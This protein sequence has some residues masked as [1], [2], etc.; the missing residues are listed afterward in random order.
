MG[1]PVKT[2]VDY[3]SHDA[4]ASDRKTLTILTKHF[5]NDGYAA[6][7]RLLEQLAKSE[8][9][10]YDCQNAENFEYLEAKFN[11]SGFS[12]TEILDKLSEIGAIDA[13]LWSNKTI[14]CG[15]FV[16]RLSE[17]YR[18]RG[19]EVP[20]KPNYCD[21]KASSAEDSA[22][23]STQSRVEESIVKKSIE[24]S[25]VGNKNVPRLIFEWYKENHG[26]LAKI[27]RLTQTRTKK[28]NTRIKNFGNGEDWGKEFCKAV[29]IAKKTPK[30][31][32]KTEINWTADFDWFIRNDENIDNVIGGK[33]EGK[34]SGAKPLHP[35]DTPNAVRLEAQSKKII[36]GKCKTN[37]EVDSFPDLRRGKSNTC[38]Y[39]GEELTE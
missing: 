4:D 10:F 8:G 5:G 29:E 38:P 36:C 11:L 14:W 3:F 37:V 19:R 20:V 35:Q 28:I 39:C 12:A 15:K 17:V 27:T 7:F 6:W 22:T 2:G 1:R 16:D 24:D 25:L 13:D 18:K 30:M 9:H 33:Y 32:G 31:I 34:Q 26:K 21:R 23:G